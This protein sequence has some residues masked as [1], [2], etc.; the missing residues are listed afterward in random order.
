VQWNLDPL[1]NAHSSTQDVQVMDF[2]R[3]G[4]RTTT[5]CLCPKLGNKARVTYRAGPQSMIGFFLATSVP[6]SPPVSTMA[7]PQPQK[8]RDGVLSTLDVLIQ[9]L[10]LA[11]DACGI[12]PAQIALGSS[13]V[14]LTLIRVRFP[15]LRE[16]KHLIHVSLGHN[17]QRSRLRR[18]WARLRWCMPNPLP[19]IEGK[20]IGRPHPSRPRCNGRSYYV[21]Q[22]NDAHAG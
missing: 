20:T 17:G 16:D 1:L 22:T 10:N 15:T 3:W 14:L 9:A 6:H 5:S 12:P 19:E 18:T 8:G 7:S 4:N 21:S 11:K 2:Q 13:C